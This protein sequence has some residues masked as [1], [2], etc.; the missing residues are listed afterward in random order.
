MATTP[1]P[2]R[3]DLWIAGEFVGTF[4]AT[5]HATAEDAVQ[6]LNVSADAVAAEISGRYFTMPLAEFA[7]VEGFGIQPATWHVWEDR[8]VSV[9]GRT[10]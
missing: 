4:K 10:G 9:P 3:R 8:L 6:H 5:E 2:K 7:I 1:E